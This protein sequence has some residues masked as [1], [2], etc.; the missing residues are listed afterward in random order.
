MG[1]EDFKKLFNDDEVAE[2]QAV[3]DELAA[4]ATPASQQKQN[5]IWYDGDEGIFS[6][7]AVNLGGK[8]IIWV[9]VNNSVEL[10]QEQHKMPVSPDVTVHP[11]HVLSADRNQFLVTKGFAA[12]YLHGDG[13]GVHIDGN[14]VRAYVAPRVSHWVGHF[15][16]V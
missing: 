6:R 16:G 9:M 7:Y 11:I 8:T 15:Y 2:L 12:R 13:S 1:D 10:T 14:T 4:E 5:G 3:Y